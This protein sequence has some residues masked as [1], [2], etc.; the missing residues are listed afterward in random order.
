MFLFG[1]AVEQSTIGQIL[2]PRTSDG[3]V[4]QLQQLPFHAEGGH[5]EVGRS[6]GRE[7]AHRRA[8]LFSTRQRPVLP[9]R[10]MRESVCY[11][12]YYIVIF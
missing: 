2:H 5:V 6:K 7:T 11:I 1:L 10:R 12:L 9:Q 8:L 3:P 4:I